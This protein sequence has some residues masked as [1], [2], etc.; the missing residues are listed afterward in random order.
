MSTAYIYNAIQGVNPDGTYRTRENP[1]TGGVEFGE[2]LSYAGMEWWFPFEKVTPIPNYALCELDHEKSTPNKGEIVAQALYKNE[3]VDGDVIAQILT[4]HQGHHKRGIQVIEG[5]P[6]GEARVVFAGVN[7]STRMPILTEC[8][9]KEA[10]KA[11]RERAAQT[12]LEYKKQC[13]QDYFN[14][15]RERMTG[16]QG[17]NR[18]DPITR[19]Y[20]DELNVEDIDDVTT[21]QKNVGGLS[22]EVIEALVS[23]IYKGQEINGA[24]LQEAVETVRK[25]GKAQLSNAQTGKRRHSLNLADNKAKWDAEHPEEVNT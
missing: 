22:P 8:P 6:T 5:K 3:F 11:E 23:A 13:I 14:S 1:K 16:G 12:A 9:E 17:K 25:A 2:L 10:T 19:V 7:A 4:Q 15:K 20:M 24:K 21:H 18:P